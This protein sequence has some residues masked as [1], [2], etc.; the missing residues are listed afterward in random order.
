MKAIKIAG[1]FVSLIFIPAVVFYA[2]MGGF[3]KIEIVEKNTEPFE[4]IFSTH[5]GPYENLGKSWKQFE[6][7][8]KEAGLEDCDALGVYL[9]PPGTPKEKLR[10]VLG[11]K[12]DHLGDEKKL[13]IKQKFPFFVFPTSK[14]LFTQFPFRNELSYMFAPMR[15]YPKFQ[16]TLEKQSNLPLI[17][18]ELYGFESSRKKIEFFLP[19]ESNELDRDRLISAF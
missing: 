19:M 11:C 17:A 16:K 5:L 7:K 8:F 6:G 9:D 10:T 14:G 13:E 12:I 4:F 15:V 18:L 2:Y 3:T 1:V